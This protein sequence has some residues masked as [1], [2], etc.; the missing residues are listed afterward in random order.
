MYEANAGF[1]DVFGGLTQNF[2]LAAREIT[3]YVCC[4]RK[5][6]RD[7]GENFH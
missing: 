6:R 1:P 3:Q 5:P 7:D 2:L 4:Y